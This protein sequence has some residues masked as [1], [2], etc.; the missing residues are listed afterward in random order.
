MTS[1]SLSGALLLACAGAGALAGVLLSRSLTRPLLRLGDVAERLAD[2][3]LSARA[4]TAGG[5]EIAA[6]GGAFNQMAEEL[7]RSH[8]SFRLMFERN[9]LPMWVFDL[10]TLY[11][12]EVN[13]T[14]VAHY[15][16][17]REEFLRMQITEIR[18]PEE[19][20]RVR[21]AFAEDLP[22]LELHGH[23]IHRR[24]SG[25]L[26]DVESASHVIEF[27]GRRA[28]LV[29]VSDVTARV[30]TEAEIRRLNE[31]LEQRVAERTAQLEAANGELE[32]F[33]Y[34]VSH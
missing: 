24:K 20:E 6:V 12:L 22:D 1:H 26:M 23:W 27:G 3:D 10:E 31:S 30:R 13:Q 7:Q 19:A 33:T 15:G 8:G 29:V 28:R 5:R 18:P 17:S 14:A 16:Y 25:E 11:F 32:A 21:R 9:P 34:T 2:G 4:T